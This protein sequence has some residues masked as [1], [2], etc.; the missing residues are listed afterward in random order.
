[1]GNQFIWSDRAVGYLADH[2]HVATYTARAAE[3]NFVPRCVRVV[4]A[5]ATAGSLNRR[6]QSS[7]YGMASDAL[8]GDLC[9]AQGAGGPW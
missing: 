1:L 2:L 6:F 5:K 8:L 4:V 9:G 7:P 3:S